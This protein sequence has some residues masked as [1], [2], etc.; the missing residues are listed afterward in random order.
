M[1]GGPAELGSCSDCVYQFWYI[2]GKSSVVREIG[3]M[4]KLTGLGGDCV[5][6]REDSGD[7]SGEGCCD[8]LSS[9]HALKLD[10]VEVDALSRRTDNPMSALNVRKGLES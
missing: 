10:I 8:W 2:Q 7:I 9:L 6:M 3:P 4:S 1:G 5:G